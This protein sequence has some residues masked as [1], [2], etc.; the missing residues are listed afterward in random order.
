MPDDR[1]D[2]KNIAIISWF[3]RIVS[4]LYMILAVLAIVAPVVG[5]TSLL[6]IIFGLL[7]LPITQFG[8]TIRLDI[9]SGVEKNLNFVP[10]LGIIA[11]IVAILAFLSANKIKKLDRKGVLIYCS[12]VSLL[13]I[14][15]ILDMVFGNTGAIKLLITLFSNPVII[16]S[17]PLVLISTIMEIVFIAIAVY[18]W[19]SSKNWEK[20]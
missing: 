10:I 4:I 11:L 2:Y 14:G 1:R 5:Y 6:Y 3:I 9:F 7:V 13:L 16:M 15:N 12:I 17:N 19:K 18:L 20:I 8:I